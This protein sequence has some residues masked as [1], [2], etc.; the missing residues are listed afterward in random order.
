MKL[1]KMSTIRKLV[2]SIPAELTEAEKQKRV[3]DAFAK[4]GRRV[5]FV[6]KIGEVVRE[7]RHLD[8]L[9]NAALIPIVHSSDFLVFAICPLAGERDKLRMAQIPNAAVYRFSDGE[10]RLYTA[11]P[12][13][14]IDRLEELA[15]HFCWR[16]ELEKG[17]VEWA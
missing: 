17:N 13:R 4:D 3:N 11:I 1:M 6:Y 7:L 16:L 15:D 2:D 9:S 12:R 10:F 5:E 14:Q 8:G